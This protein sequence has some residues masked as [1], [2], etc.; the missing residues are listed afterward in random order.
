MAPCR[1]VS[2]RAGITQP[3]QASLPDPT[4]P[5]ALAGFAASPPRP[6]SSLPGL[7]L[8][9]HLPWAGPALPGVEGTSPLTPHPGVLGFRGP[10]GCRED[11]SQGPQSP[12]GTWPL[13]SEQGPQLLRADA[14]LPSGAP[15]QP[16]WA[17]IAPS[18]PPLPACPHLEPQ[19]LLSCTQI[20]LQS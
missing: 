15:A 18:L 20:W 14:L 8:P 9:A 16:P 13:A 11:S 19:T 17:A 1:G 4:L 2:Q 7:L 10:A 6:A 3:L 5:E 12:V